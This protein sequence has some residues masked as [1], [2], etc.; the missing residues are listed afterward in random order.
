MVSLVPLPVFAG[1]LGSANISEIMVPKTARCNR[2][3]SEA[4]LL[5]F[6]AA[7]NTA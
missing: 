4:A 6:H 2:I 5:A 1:H 3:F 7:S